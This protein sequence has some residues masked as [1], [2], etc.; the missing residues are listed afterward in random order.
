M[1]TPLADDNIASEVTLTDLGK[2]VAFKPQQT[3]KWP[4]CVQLLGSKLCLVHQFQ[5]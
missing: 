5:I 1:T 4:P 2:S 3:T